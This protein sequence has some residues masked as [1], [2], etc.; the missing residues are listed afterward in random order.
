MRRQELAATLKLWQKHHGR[1]PVTADKLHDSVK[2]ALDPQDRGRQFIAR[3]LE[4]ITGTRLGGMKI[5]REK[6]SHYSA[7]TYALLPADE[8]DCHRGHGGASEE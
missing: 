2:R 1:R 3:R 6:T 8:S 4:T 7:A 5:T